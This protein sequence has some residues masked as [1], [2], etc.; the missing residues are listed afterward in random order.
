MKG[1]KNFPKIS[2]EDYAKARDS[3]KIVI[4]KSKLKPIE[5]RNI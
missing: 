3:I 4:K 2:P 1:S 5:F